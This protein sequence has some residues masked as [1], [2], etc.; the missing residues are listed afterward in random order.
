MSSRRCFKCEQPNLVVWYLMVK[1]DLL[2]KLRREKKSIL[3][4]EKSP[5][6]TT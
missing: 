2:G 5:K 4:N 6:K 1:Q 3:S